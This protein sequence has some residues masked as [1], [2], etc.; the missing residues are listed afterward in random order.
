MRQNA[1]L[2]KQQIRRELE[3]AYTTRLIRQETADIAALVLYEEFGF[4]PER[5]KRFNQRLNAKLNEL[6]DIAGQDTKDLEYTKAKIDQELMAACG[7]YYLPRE[8]RYAW[9]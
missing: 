4:G 9:D 3:R 2:A 6:L 7:P 1:Y 8:E 5:Q